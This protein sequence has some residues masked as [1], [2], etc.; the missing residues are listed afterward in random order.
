MAL[1][2]LYARTSLDFIGF[3]SRISFLWYET[4]ILCSL[5]YWFLNLRYTWWLWCVGL[6]FMLIFCCSLI[7]W[8]PTAWSQGFING[9]VMPE[10]S[11]KRDHLLNSLPP[12]T[13]QTDTS[14]SLLS[15]KVGASWF[16]ILHIIG[17]NTRQLLLL[18]IMTLC[19]SPCRKAQDMLGCALGKLNL[20]GIKRCN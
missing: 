5:I 4:K 14:G 17:H 19:S 10:A 11:I 16:M 6:T 18:L 1:F 13:I 20:D 2:V 12:L 3:Q 9:L 15:T 8:S 7:H